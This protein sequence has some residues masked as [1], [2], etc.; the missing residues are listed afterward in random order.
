V[1]GE[2]DYSLIVDGTALAATGEG[3]LA[4]APTRAVLHRVAGAAG[5]G[6]TC[7]PVGTA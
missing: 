3:A 1:A 7:R 5:D 4:V 6:P 2:P